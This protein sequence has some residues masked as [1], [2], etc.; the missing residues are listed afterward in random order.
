MG[1]DKN[2]ILFSALQV[3]SLIY[4]FRREKKNLKCLLNEN[5]D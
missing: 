5:S 3:G 2:V 1:R 4:I